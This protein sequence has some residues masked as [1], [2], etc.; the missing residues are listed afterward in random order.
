[1]FLLKSIK[2]TSK[3]GWDENFNEV[4]Y[5]CNSLDYSVEFGKKLIKSEENST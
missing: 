2:E 3:R 5:D 1:M 4:F